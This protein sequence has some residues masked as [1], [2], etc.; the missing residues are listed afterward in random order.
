MA[1]QSSLRSRRTVTSACVLVGLVVACSQQ[2]RPPEAP[3]RPIVAVS[4]VPLGWIV[5]QLAGD[6]VQLEV[7]VP[8]GASPAMHEPTPAQMRAVSRARIY[9]KVGHPAFAFERAW[10][11][12]LLERNDNMAIV[13]A[14]QG[15]RGGPDDP[16]VWAS[17]RV[18]RAL[19][20]EV[21]QQ[22]I[23]LLPQDEAALQ[24]ALDRV[25]AEIDS[26][27]TD[28]RAILKDAGSCTFYV[29]HP[30]WGWFAA[31]YGLEQVAIEEKGAHGAEPSPDHLARLIRR[32]R[33]DG[34]KVIA[35]QP[36]YSD[37]SAELMAR[38]IGARVEVLDP[39][40]ADWATNLR[41]VARKLQE[42]CAR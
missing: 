22:L 39:L 23:T 20:H 16:H 36:Q 25:V 28:I 26:V 24:A 10:L 42:A 1:L 18:M 19:A 34:T 3:G 35:V 40:H 31:D 33:A 38:E 11:G 15:A 21:A 12:H 30:A 29:F 9:V 13:S 7:M 27:D 17:P 2:E 4:V 32:A 5:Q 37:R 14:A 41:S 8:P 6:R